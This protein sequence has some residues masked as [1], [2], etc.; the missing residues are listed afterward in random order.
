MAQYAG[1]SRDN[2]SYL[3]EVSRRGRLQA[4]QHPAWLPPLNSATHTYTH[5]HDTITLTSSYLSTFTLTFASSSTPITSHPLTLYTPSSSHPITFPIPR[6]SLHPPFHPTPFSTPLFLPPI[7]PPSISHHDSLPP[8]PPTGRPSDNQTGE[9]YCNV[10]T[11]K[12][13]DGEGGEVEAWPSIR[14]WRRPC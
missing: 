4:A 10:Q 7:P 11:G 3:P 1:E 5:T 6:S 2:A 8:S 13:G 14:G 12:V 9:D